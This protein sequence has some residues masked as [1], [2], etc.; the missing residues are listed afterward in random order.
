M[1]LLPP[2]DSWADRPVLLRAD[3]RVHRQ[4]A[5]ADLRIGHVFPLSSALFEGQALV[6][7]HGTSEDCDRSYFAGKKRRMGF[8]VRG[9]FTQRI[10]CAAVVCGQD[11]EKPLGSLPAQWAVRPAGGAQ[12]DVSVSVAG[13]PGRPPVSGHATPGLGP[14]DSSAQ[15]TSRRHYLH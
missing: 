7:V 6:R 8:V 14:G 1:D 15:G 5:S 13:Y 3:A 11:F 2:V 4:A 9:R 12:L 10:P